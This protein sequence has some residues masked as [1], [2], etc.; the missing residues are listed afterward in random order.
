MAYHLNRLTVKLFFTRIDLSLNLINYKKRF[1]NNKIEIKKRIFD[2]KKNLEFYK[3]S[4]G[5]A[6]G[7]KYSVS[8]RSS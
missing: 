5:S 7:F 2:L 3:G 1:W 6:K 8:F 4:Y